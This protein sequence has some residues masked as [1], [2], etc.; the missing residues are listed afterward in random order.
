MLTFA[1]GVNSQTLTV[2]V[3]SDDI[4]EYPDETLGIAL[5]DIRYNDLAGLPQVH[6]GAANATMTITDDGGD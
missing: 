5:S 3:L 1:D 6:M 4:F 2:V